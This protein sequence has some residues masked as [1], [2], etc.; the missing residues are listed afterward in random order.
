MRKAVIGFGLLGLIA[1]TAQGE[2]WDDQVIAF[3][4]KN[5]QEYLEL[6]SIP[7]IA[8]VP[9]DIQRN[10]GA[11]ADGLQH[12]ALG[13]RGSHGGNRSPSGRRAGTHPHDGRYGPDGC[14]G[15]R[16]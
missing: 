12:R 3:S 1:G 10:A 7:D 5:F 2:G 4:Q 14:P 15:Q 9:A 6:L 8:A 16:T 13:L 11:R